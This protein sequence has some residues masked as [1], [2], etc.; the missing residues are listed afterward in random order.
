MSIAT[1]HKFYRR[2]RQ[3]TD[4]GVIAMALPECLLIDA[5]VGDRPRLFTGLAACDRAAH[6]APGFIPTHARNLARA[7]HRAALP[8]QIDQ[9]PLH[10]QR[11]ATPRL[12]PG[13]PYLFDAMRGALQPRNLR[14][15]VGL[16]L[17]CVEM[18]PRAFL[19]MI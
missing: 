13:A 3:V 11:E 7:F 9:Q 14:T 15:Q 17:A 2:A 10:Q 5:D 1:G 12:G 6:H 18:T 8:D 16:K 19:G 4:D